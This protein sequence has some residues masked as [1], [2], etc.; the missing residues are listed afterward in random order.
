MNLKISNP[1]LIQFFSAIYEY[2]QLGI[3]PIYS[4]IFFFVMNTSRKKLFL[5]MRAHVVL[6]STA[7]KMSLF[8]FQ[9]LL[10]SSSNMLES[11][12]EQSWKSNPNKDNLSLAEIYLDSVEQL[13]DGTSIT[14]VK[15][16]TNIEVAACSK[17]NCTNTVF[18]VSVSLGNSD[19]QNVTTAGFKQ[20]ENYWPT[21]DDERTPNSI[22]VSTTTDNKQLDSVEL[23][24]DFQLLKPRPRNVR[25]DC[26]AWDNATRTWS[27]HGCKWQGSSNEGRCV[28]NHLSSFAILMSRS[29]VKVPGIN[30]MTYAGLSVSILSL[31]I[32]LV[33]EVIVW[34]AVVKTSNS[35]VRHTAHINI[36]LVLLI[37]DC[38][39]LGSSDPNNISEIWC[40]T[41]VV[42]KHFCYL[43]MFFWMLSLSVM[44]LHQTVFMFHHVS[45][46]NYLRFSLVLGY[47][48][49]FLIV[50]IT[51]LANNG[52]A[53]GLYYS[54]DTCWLIYDGLL[55][56]SIHTFFIPVGVIVFINIFSMGVVILKLLDHPVSTENFVEKTATRT[57]I[58][59]VILYT[60]IFGVTWL[61]GF[62]VMA[63]DLTS[64]NITFAVHY[65]F[66]LLNAFQG[67]F[68]LLTTCLG[69]KQ[70]VRITRSTERHSKVL[71]SF[72]IGFER[73]KGLQH[74]PAD[75]Y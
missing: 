47:V 32:S 25:I 2:C 41:L 6:K 75:K 12:L 50:T 36:C 13:I 48:C 4:C 31:A 56:G 18:N 14:T 30:E 15:K 16:K 8:S 42:L 28:C 23:Q 64:G 68:I 11:S 40:K 74:T 46:N 70:F 71:N 72:D 44:L 55:K 52:G 66:T 37:A 29:Q 35:H 65:A 9:D 51:A 43:S 21:S 69:D 53:E 33:I 62:G 5:P 63:L 38:C 26:V 67:L 57:V 22:I 73:K 7:I 39:F 59:S 61:F 1:V 34:S 49:P 3:F 58:R 45:K 10:E 19:A 24:I 27:P 54:R 17:P 20:L 60:P